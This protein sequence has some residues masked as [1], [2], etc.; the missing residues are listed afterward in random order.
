MKNKKDKNFKKEL[1]KLWGVKIKIV[2]SREWPAQKLKAA[3]K[4]QKKLHPEE[5]IE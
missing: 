4:E 3:V 5:F 2:E 1:E